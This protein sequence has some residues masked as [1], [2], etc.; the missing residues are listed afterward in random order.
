MSCRHVARFF[1]RSAR[2]TSAYV[3]RV[4]S[5]PRA[6]PRGREDRAGRVQRREAHARHLVHGPVRA[7]WLRTHVCWGRSDVDT[8][9]DC[10][11][12]ARPATTT[13]IAPLAPSPFCWATRRTWTKQ[14]V[15]HTLCTPLASSSLT[16]LA[17]SSS[18]QYCVFG[19]MV[20]GES[21]LRKMEQ[22]RLRCAQLRAPVCAHASPAAR[23]R[24][25]R[26]SARAS[27]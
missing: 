4:A 26:R 9:G 20:S 1:A 2:G 17:L 21:V 8:R 23:E 18:S 14:C 25:L 24:R 19:K 10:L 3:L 12:P 13:P 22:V 16:A 15:P 11:S 6:A 7:A 27:S 5:A